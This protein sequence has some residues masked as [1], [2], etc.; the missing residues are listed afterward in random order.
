ME[1]RAGVVRRRRVGLARHLVDTLGCLGWALCQGEESQAEHSTMRGPQSLLVL[2][3]PPPPPRP[4]LSHLI[5]T[6]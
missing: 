4:A 3:L 5:K 1:R 2:K 6:P